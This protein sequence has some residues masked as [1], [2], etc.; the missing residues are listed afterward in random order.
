MD[1]HLENK[2][3]GKEKAY[4][5]KYKEKEMELASEVH[6]MDDYKAQVYDSFVAEKEILIGNVK[7]LLDYIENGPSVNENASVSIITDEDAY[8]VK[9]R[10]IFIISKYQEQPELLDPILN[11]FLVPMIKFIQKF[12]REKV[13]DMVAPYKLSFCMSSLFDMIYNLSKVRGMKKI[14]KFFP[15][16]VEDLELLVNFV[17]NLQVQSYEWYLHYV[18]LLWLSMVVI[19]P[20]DLETIDSTKDGEESLLNKIMSFCEGFLN[21]TGIN[22]QAAS[23][24]LAKILTRPDVINQGYLDSFIDRMKLK[25]EE[26]INDSTK[27]FSLTGVL[28][29][30]TDILKTG[31]RE[32]LLS[33]ASKVF[34]TF[35][36]TKSDSE[37]VE[38]SS[39]LKKLRV[40]FANNLG[41]I[42]LKPKVASWRYKM[43]SRSLMKNLESQATQ[44]Q[45]ESSDEEMDDDQ[46]DEDFECLETIITILLE[47]LKD[48]ET[49]IRWAAAKGIGKIT[50]RLSRDLADQIVEDVLK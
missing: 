50:G 19:V 4:I 8:N 14:I 43:G 18:M 24:V 12:L 27:I 1:S 49:S 2:F 5:E 38:S 7:D 34:D 10:I 40:K 16:D 46:D 29:V 28:H 33:R 30:M 21:S 41:L 45:E 39:I 36:T 32:Q 35:I 44:K 15:H 48:Q 37:F 26:N 20:F 42:Y 31:Q 22:R 11:D 23:L 17:I 3:L 13:K 9:S 25:Y 6:N 47:H